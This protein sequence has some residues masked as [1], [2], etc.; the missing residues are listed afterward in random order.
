MAT[1]TISTKTANKNLTEVI[2]S[3]IPFIDAKRAEKPTAADWESIP[4]KFAE[5]FDQ[6]IFALLESALYNH[7]TAK[8]W[9]KLDCLR[10]EAIWAALR[11][12]WNYQDSN[13]GLPG[14]ETFPEHIVPEMAEDLLR[15]FL[16]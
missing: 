3:L 15:A 10:D 2:L 12:I 1:Q 7:D 14:I 8:G 6:E 13:E 4:A 16:R 11:F 5:S 9:T